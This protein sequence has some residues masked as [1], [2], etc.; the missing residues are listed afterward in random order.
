MSILQST[1]LFSQLL[2]CA[3]GAHGPVPVPEAS[4]LALRYYQSGNWW[5][6]LNTSFGLLIPAL[7]L[8]TGFSARLRTLATRIGRKWFLVIAV[9]YILYW[10]INF[11]LDLPRYYLQDFVRE[12][13]YGLSNQTL[14]KWAIDGA[15][16]LVTDLV[17]GTLLLWIPYLL[18]KKSPRRWWIYTC[19][20][21]VP[22]L[23]AFFMIAPIWLMPLFNRSG[24][25]QDKALEGKI[26]ALAARAGIEDIQVSQLETSVDSNRINATVAGFGRTKRILV[27]DTMLAKLNQDEV[28]FGV[29]HEMGHYVLGHS[30]KTILFLALLAAATLYAA[31]R[32][33][34]VLLSRFKHRFGFDQLSDIASLPL[35]ILLIN[36]FSLVVTP[37][38][39]SYSRHIEHE[40]DRFGLEL[41]HL[42]LAA[43]TGF[44]KE[45]QESL[46]NPRPGAIYVLFRV[47]HPPLAERIDF[48]ND[49]KPWETGAHLRYEAHFKSDK[50]K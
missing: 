45:Q 36:L 41:T 35:L 19:A 1:S 42:N 23:F 44:V 8:F 37:A 22:L 50:A 43:A 10:F 34:E 5:W 47:N 33:A 2:I 17:M 26:I 4:A 16:G 6:I 18:L 9:Y 46:R 39:M 25:I 48:C 27:T 24:P 21:I 13:A 7:F 29:G 14:G 38:F 11:L 40:A 28:L 49:Y 15:M 30:W 32:V 31:K 12:H 3:I 20:L